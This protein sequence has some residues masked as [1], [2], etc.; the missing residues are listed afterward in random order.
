MRILS[1]VVGRDGLTPND[2]LYLDFGD[3]FERA[4]VHQTEPRSFEE[5][6]AIGWEILAMLPPGELS[7]VSDA[8]IARHITP[9]LEGTPDE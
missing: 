5:S 6:S 1:S 9:I 2:R 3:R 7:R 8:Q 4:F